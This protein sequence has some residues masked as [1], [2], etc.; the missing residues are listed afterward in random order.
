MK[1]IEQFEPQQKK[2]LERLARIPRAKYRFYVDDQA[3]GP[4]SLVFTFLDSVV[5][6]IRKLVR[7]ITIEPTQAVKRF[8]QDRQSIEDCLRV[9]VVPHSKT[10]RPPDPVSI[11]NAAFCFYLTS[12]PDV[13][14]EFEGPAAKNDLRIY[15]LWTKRLEMWTMKA[16]EDS[17]VQD[18]FR[19]LRGTAL[20]SFLEK[21]S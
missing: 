11:I 19:T 15:S 9:G 2:L 6:A 18:R 14:G 4:Q 7:E 16:I 3:L 21:K 12:L 5:P 17:Q 13:I 1:A 10:S 8:E 20:W